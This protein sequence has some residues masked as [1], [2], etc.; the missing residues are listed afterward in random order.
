M[1][2]KIQMVWEKSNIPPKIQLLKAYLGIALKSLQLPIKASLERMSSID[3][4]T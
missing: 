1:L 3:Y 2:K 4:K